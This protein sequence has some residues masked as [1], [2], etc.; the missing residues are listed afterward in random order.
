MRR[1]CDALRVVMCQ[2]RPAA[3]VPVQIQTAIAQRGVRKHYAQLPGSPASRRYP[4]SQSRASTFP[5]LP[6]QSAQ[7]ENPSAPASRKP[8]GRS[9]V[10]LTPLNGAAL[11]GLPGQIYVLI[12]PAFSGRALDAGTQVAREPRKLA[13]EVPCASIRLHQ[14]RTAAFRS[15]V[16]V[17][18]VREPG[19]PVRAR[20]DRGVRAP[21][22]FRF[23]FVAKRG[24][25][26]SPVFL[27]RA[28]RLP[29]VRVG[30]SDP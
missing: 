30:K 22:T 4:G 16:P 12:P 11:R 14:F 13:A 25:K 1:A 24:P 15:V 2:F 27:I 9:V 8:D 29:S 18:R 3:S 21:A 26:S 5:S 7:A 20:R 19:E 17:P 10:K 28:F 23:Q 6:I